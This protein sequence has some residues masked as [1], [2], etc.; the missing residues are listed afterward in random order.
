MLPKAALKG[1]HFV[2]LCTQ[3]EVPILF[4][5]NSTPST[6]S[7]SEEHEEWN[8]RIN[9]HAKL[10]SAVAC[11]TVPKITVVVGNSIGAD[12]YMMVRYFA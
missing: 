5:Q 2:Q 9:A 7:T 3:R 1:A 12:N 4:L 10:M 8:E 6:P 11:S